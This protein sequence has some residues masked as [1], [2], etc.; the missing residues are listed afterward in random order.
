MEINY[1]DRV[2]NYTDWATLMFVLSIFIIALNRSVFQV[3]FVEFMRLGVSDKYTKIYK[4]SSNINSGFTMSMFFV[5]LISFSF[6]ILLVLS[7]YKYST[8]ENI[9]V[10]I[11][12]VTFLGVFIL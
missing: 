8:K 3:R 10:F 1:Q 11:Q 7:H 5:Q 6:F 9:I 12:I 2:L 4:D